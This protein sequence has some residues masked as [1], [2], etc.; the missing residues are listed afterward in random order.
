MSK[1]KGGVAMIGGIASYLF[2]GWDELL[3]A[4]CIFMVLDYLTGLLRAFIKKEISSNIGF[5]GIARKMVIFVVLI[6]ANMLDMVVNVEAGLFRGMVC[7]FYITNEGI[8]ILEN[9]A[10]VGLP[11]P[12]FMRDALKQLSNGQKKEKIE[13]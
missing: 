6:L 13:K 10:S 1:L 4:L 9:C 5:H 3:I 2:G 7:F 8:S 12:E 11:I